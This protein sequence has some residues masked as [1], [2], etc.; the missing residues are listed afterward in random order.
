MLNRIINTLGC[1]FIALLM[2]DK[3]RAQLSL[4]TANYTENFNTLVKTGTGTTLP[5]GWL[6][7]ETGTNANS[8]YSANNGASNSGDTYSYG[9]TDADD[10]SLGGL[11]SG[12]LTPL[13]GAY[14]TNNTGKAITS[15]KI[16]YTGEQWRLGTAGRADT[17]FFQYSL[18][19]TSMTTG[20]WN[21]VD[22][23]DFAS[24]VTTGTTGALDGNASA[25]KRNLSH[26]ISGI[27]IGVGQT[28]YIRW[29]DFDATGAD[30]G[31]A[32]DDFSIEVQGPVSD[33]TPPTVASFS[34][35][36]NATN[37]AQ[38]PS[39]VI[40]FSETVQ[41]GSGNILVKKF[42]DN[43]TVASIDVLSSAVA[44]SGTRATINVQG[45]ALSTKYYI[46]IPNGAFTDPA[47]N[48]FAGFTG[49]ATWSF[50]TV[51]VPEIKFPFNDCVTSLGRSWTQ[52]S[53]RGDSVW[54]CSVF[55]YNNSIGLQVNGFVTGS[56]A[57]DNEDWLISP[58]LDLTAFQYPTLSFYMR[59]RFSGPDV[60]IFVAKNQSTVPAPGSAAWTP[61]DAI[62][63]QAN[64]D[65]WTLVDK[66]DLTAHKSATTYIAIRY[67]SSPAQGAQRVTIDQLEVN[68]AASA[69]VPFVHFQSPSL[70]QFDQTT[71]GAPSAPRSFQFQV[72][73][74]QTDLTISAPAQFQLSKDNAVFSS[75]LAYTP[76]QLSGGPKTMFMRFV[77]AA[78]KTIVQGRMS[79]TSSGADTRSVELFGNTYARSATLDVVNWNLLW[80]GSSAS[81]QGPANDDQAQ[82][83]IKRIMDSLDADLYAFV[84]VVD[85]NRF[86]NLIESLPGYG[87]VVSDY[88]SNAPDP[89]S[90]N[91][92]V[93]QKLAFAYRRSVITNVTA[94]GMMRNSTSAAANW[95]AGRFPYLMQAD[96][97]NGNATKRISFISLH[98]KA[99][100]TADDFQR[101]KAGAKELKDTLDASFNAANVIIL[102]DFNDDL[103][104]TISEGIS[105]ALSSYDDLVKD[106]TDADRYKSVS[107]LLS[108]TGHNSIIGYADVVDHVVISNEMETDYL[109]GSVRLVRDATD[110]ISNYATTTSD[111]LPVL[112]RYLLPVSNTTSIRTYAP[113][114]IGLQLLQNPVKDRLLVRLQPEAGTL[115]YEIISS[116]GQQVL[117]GAPV[118]VTSGSRTIEVDLNNAADGFYILKVTNNQKT[119]LKKFI[120]QH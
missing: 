120:K 119:F 53:V 115:Q 35:A 9:A 64:S 118:R 106:S 73:N 60:R 47:F 96:V 67:L 29:L 116:Q 24:P 4:T 76:A 90:N 70:I 5:A 114:Q 50:T 75:S 87:Y 117:A 79:F 74:P 113:E 21:E 92:A 94:R 71:L 34:P 49:S 78:E 39:L 48:K 72:L 51:A 109:N 95:A 15:L 80:F 91:Y 23:L 44:V 88:C 97:V 84:E 18:D 22:Q 6:I 101:R 65:V 54:A 43:T 8:S 45:L 85:I 14:F 12:S 52:Q 13:F 7:Q 68:N 33:N 105:P 111:H 10:R 104:S 30:D 86:R 100:N 102:G 81:G 3:V 46:E 98:G 1:F 58:A 56:G 89:S 103:D 11:R 42:S 37:V 55:G 40:T 83:N 19:A 20:Q 16:S 82:V 63:A 2:A 108:K 41:K 28:F 17:I 27:N 93:G 36:N 112:S 38:S 31:L 61:V 107:L 110:W 32:V 26:T 69:P 62:L 59:T 57:A 25:S 99:G 66:I 77:P